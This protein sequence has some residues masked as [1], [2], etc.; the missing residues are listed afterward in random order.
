MAEKTFGETLTKIKGLPLGDLDEQSTKLGAIL[1]LL[2]QSGWDTEDPTEV[3]PELLVRVPKSPQSKVDYSLRI[4]NP[5]RISNTDLLFLEAKAWSRSLGEGEESQLDEYCRAAKVNRGVLTNGREWRFYL[6]KPARKWEQKLFLKLDLC[7]D[8]PTVIEEKFIE[9]LHR[10]NFAKP[11]SIKQM[12][13]AAQ[14]LIREREDDEK[15]FKKLQAALNS[16]SDNRQPLIPFLAGLAETDGITPTDRQ[17]NAFMEKFE[18]GIICSPI[19]IKG[20][21][22][23]PVSYS[24][25]LGSVKLADN[26]PVRRNAWSQLLISVCNLMQEHNSGTFQD[27]ILSVPGWFSDHKDDPYVIPIGDGIYTRWGSSGD[28]RKV[29]HEVVAAFGYPADSLTIR[30]KG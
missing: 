21:R 5:D 16:L 8:S 24:F 30:E 12:V 28:F 14:V 13:D 17:V 7:A 9:F 27:R 11:Q 2:R 4:N 18:V 26:Q 29:C 10:D 23:R 22:K 19:E 1:P 20:G 15:A 3:I 25:Q 6:H